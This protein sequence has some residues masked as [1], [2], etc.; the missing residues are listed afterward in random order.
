MTPD[1]IERLAELAYQAFCDAQGAH[2]R[3]W[4]GPDALP[5]H[6]KH[7]WRA[8]AEALD[9]LYTNTRPVAR[10]VMVTTPVSVSGLARELASTAPDKLLAV[11]TDMRRQG[12][13][14]D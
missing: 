14:A 8:V 7:V 1:Q 12:M 6:R 4:T 9:T 13:S 5:E 3:P 10:A 2:P 11:L